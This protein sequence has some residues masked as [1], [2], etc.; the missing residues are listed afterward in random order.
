MKYFK[1]LFLSLLVS[2]AGL[3]L[4]SPHASAA[5]TN[6]QPEDPDIYYTVSSGTTDGTGSNLLYS[7]EI[8]IRVYGGTND[9]G[10]INFIHGNHCSAGSG[11]DTDTFRETNFELHGAYPNGSIQLFDR[12]SSATNKLQSSAGGS[13]CGTVSLNIPAGALTLSSDSSHVS[14]FGTRLYTGIIKVYMN[15]VDST[16]NGPLNVFKIEGNGYWTGSIAT[17][18]WGIAPTQTFLGRPS[19]NSTKT[20]NLP[21]KPPCSTFSGATTSI[22]ATLRWFDDDSGTGYQPRFNLRLYE[23]DEGPGLTG[24]NI[25]I[26][27]ERSGEGSGASTVVT[28]RK[29]KKYVWQWE[30]ITNQN[31]VQ[32]NYPYESID[33]YF[34]CPDPPKPFNLVP[35]AS[36]DVDNEN[37]SIASFGGGVRGSQTNVNGVTISRL[38]EV[39]RINSTKT[40]ISPS[41]AALINQTINSSGI[42]LGIVPRNVESFNYKAGDKIC[43]ITTVTPGTGKVNAAGDIVESGPSK[44]GEDC[45]TIVN[46]PYVSFYGGDVKTCG[47]IKTFYDNGAG[48]K[49]GSGVQYIA[50]ANGSI[51]E[52]ISGSLLPSVVS[53]PKILTF[54]NKNTGTYGGSLGGTCS[55]PGDYF[56]GAPTNAETSNSISPSSFRDSTVKRYNGNT[57]LSGGILNNSSRTALYIDGDLRITGDIGYASPSWLSESAIPSLHVYVKGNIY[58]QPNVTNLTGF[59]VAQQKGTDTGIIFT[60]ANDNVRVTTNQLTSCAKQ[61]SV[62]GAFASKRT[63]F[64]RVANSLRDGTIQERSGTPQDAF[65]FSKA[66]EKFFIGPEMYFVS[67]GASSTGGGTS[68][69]DGY[70]FITTPAPIL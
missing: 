9:G 41:T 67:P 68:S 54:A 56:S 7:P 30:G 59:F 69:G 58:I 53:S 1:T 18:G 28:L 55:A 3:F 37:P 6:I 44:S 16:L 2:A 52:F 36:V 25:R 51:T 62:R 26:I 57:V 29:G 33:F 22:N 50:Q 61:L 14:P 45:E 19:S 63:Y 60:C 17:A 5:P 20:Y 10:T 13:G 24:T 38:Y 15:P 66:A 11:W 32:V 70:Q 46:K 42:I 48:R 4:F 39:R 47:D 49:R 64:D 8:W 35:Y 31:G 34:T 23:F 27:T 40:A 65:K 43:A 21:F 12:K